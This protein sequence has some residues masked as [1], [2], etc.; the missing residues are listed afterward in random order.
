MSAVGIAFKIFGRRNFLPAILEF[1]NKFLPYAREAP[2]PILKA[3]N[4]RRGNHFQTSSAR[5]TLARDFRISK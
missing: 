5:K 1:P 3:L 4:K 2:I